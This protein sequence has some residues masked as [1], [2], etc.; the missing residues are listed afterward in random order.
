MASLI[1]TLIFALISIGVAIYLFFILKKKEPG[2][3][4]MVEISKAIEEG[5]NFF[6]IFVKG[7]SGCSILYFWCPLYHFG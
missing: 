4:K 2:N 7:F 6:R 5:G 1:I 3:E